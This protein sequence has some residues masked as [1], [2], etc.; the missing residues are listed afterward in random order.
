M[1]IEGFRKLFQT[2]IRNK[3]ICVEQHNMMIE[4]FLKLFQTSIRNK[5]VR[6]FSKQYLYVVGVF[7]NNWMPKFNRS[8]SNTKLVCEIF[9]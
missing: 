1:M 3:N 6:T 7:K 4:G 8:L 5:N 9:Y 2:S